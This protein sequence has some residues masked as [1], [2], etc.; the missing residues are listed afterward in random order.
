M[1]A[2]RPT[3]R[4]GQLKASIGC[5]DREDGMNL[6]W[7]QETKETH[8]LSKSV[9]QEKGA[10]PLASQPKTLSGQNQW[11]CVAPCER[12]HRLEGSCTYISQGRK[13]F[14]RQARL[15]LKRTFFINIELGVLR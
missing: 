5:F 15:E 12:T 1:E 14:G 13:P 8:R 6:T 10:R 4:D 2:R 9:R 3:Q 11:G 7:A